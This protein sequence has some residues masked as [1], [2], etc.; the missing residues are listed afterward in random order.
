MKTVGVVVGGLVAVLGLVWALQ[1]AGVLV[2]GNSFMEGARL[3]VFLGIV[4]MLVGGLI[5]WL[6]LRRSPRSPGGPR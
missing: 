6:G 3:W 5:A 2:T 4:T 1:G